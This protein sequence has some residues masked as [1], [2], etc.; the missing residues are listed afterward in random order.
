MGCSIQTKNE[1]RL[2]Q[3]AV[4]KFRTPTCKWRVFSLFPGFCWWF[5][6]GN[7]F[8]LSFVTVSH[9][10]LLRN[11]AFQLVRHGILAQNP[12]SKVYIFVPHTLNGGPQRAKNLSLRVEKFS[13]Y[14]PALSEHEDS[15]IF[16]GETP[17]LQISRKELYH[18]PALQKSEKPV[19]SN[20]DP[21][22]SVT[23]ASIFDLGGSWVFCV[24]SNTI[25]LQRNKSCS[26]IPSR[27]PDLA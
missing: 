6:F 1:G 17:V 22:P 15:G 23:Q 9:L 21:V 10:F 20:M 25:P 8:L 5:R 24:S 2:E 3:I 27:Y 7:V 11:F 12:D 18:L 13:P 4:P 19:V 26:D 14:H 16:R